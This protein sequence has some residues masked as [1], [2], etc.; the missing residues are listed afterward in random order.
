MTYP[1]WCRGFDAADRTTIGLDEIRAFIEKNRL[2]AVDHVEPWFAPSEFDLLDPR[3]RAIYNL[4]KADAYQ[5]AIDL[6]AP[7]CHHSDTSQGCPKHDKSARAEY[8]Q[9][10]DQ[11]TSA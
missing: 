3:E 6:L 9:E 10:N 8:D 1:C 2:A 5:H 7:G 4:G 11:E